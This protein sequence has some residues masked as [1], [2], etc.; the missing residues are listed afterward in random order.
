MREG[1]VGVTEGERGG[2]GGL[3]R[4]A[5][6]NRVTDIALRQPDI[7][8]FSGYP[9]RSGIHESY[10]ASDLRSTLNAIADK[11]RMK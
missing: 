11:E 5:L 7:Q 9:G 6:G 10:H 2:G 8:S 3:Q 1:G 4:G